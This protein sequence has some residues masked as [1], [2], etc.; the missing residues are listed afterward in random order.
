MDGAVFVQ[1][2]KPLERLA[3][4]LLEYETLTGEEIER[5]I[6]GEPPQSEDGEGGSGAAVEEKK[7]S[8]TAIPKTRP[9]KNALTGTPRVPPGA[10]PSSWASPPRRAS[11]RRSPGCSSTSGHPFELVF[12]FTA[13]ASVGRTLPPRRPWPRAR[14]SAAADSPR[15]AGRGTSL[16]GFVLIFLRC[17]SFDFKRFSLFSNLFFVFCVF[18]CFRTFLCVFQRFCTFWTWFLN[19]R[20]F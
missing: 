12:F 6:R 9:K 15:P 8:L 20:Y 3:Q 17:F 16:H 18:M 19:F 14:R 11:P 10:S 1:C 4:G 7:P 5:V 13:V 2:G